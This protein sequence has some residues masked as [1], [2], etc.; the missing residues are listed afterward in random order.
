MN[1]YLSRIGAPPGATLAELQLAHL[2]SVP[3]ENLSIH[4]GQPI[5]L[6]EDALLDK[7]VQQR[8]G[9]FCYE[10]NGAF[11]ALLTDLG[12]HV[13]RHQARVH[14][15]DGYGPPFD[16]MALIVDEQW[17]VDVGF[18]AFSHH[19]L[20]ARPGTH[21]DPAGT[22]TIT[23]AEHGDLEVALDGKPE[24]RLDPR[25]YALADFAPT[26]WWQQT[27]PDSHFTRSLTC[28]RLTETGRITLSGER[29]IT[30]TGGQR[31]EQVLGK[32]DILPAY[33][34]HFGITL[35]RVPTVG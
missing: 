22:F 17:L 6:R 19:P 13:T 10:L 20:P 2:R 18:G 32:D 8:R 9:G 24:Y 15:P 29:L 28:S 14:T 31:H 4:L 1:A 5:V 23:R 3:F 27:S 21:P 7:I 30:T 26:C 34:T 35:D 16:H 33:R 25:P 12:H 11:A